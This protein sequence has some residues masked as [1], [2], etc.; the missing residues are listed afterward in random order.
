MR[1]VLVAAGVASAIIAIGAM[2]AGA[3]GGHRSPL[4][5]KVPGEDRFA[6]G[7]IDFEGHPFVGISVAATAVAAATTPATVAAATAATSAAATVAAT[8]AAAAFRLGTGFIDGQRSA[9]D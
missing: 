7:Q 3:S 1:K 9:I 2:S 5:V 4:Q 6:R 8:A